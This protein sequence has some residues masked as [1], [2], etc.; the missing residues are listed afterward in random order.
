[1]YVGQ[2]LQK[3]IQD[4]LSLARKPQK[5]NL[6]SIWMS[7]NTCTERERGAE[8][9]KV[10]QESEKARERRRETDRPSECVYNMGLDVSGCVGGEGGG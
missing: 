5:K 9:D 6:I 3:T 1:M 2:P 4:K 10:A 8:N 7:A